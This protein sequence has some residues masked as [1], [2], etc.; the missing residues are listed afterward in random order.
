[1]RFRDGLLVLGIIVL[2]L[3]IF[4]VISFSDILTVFVFG[5]KALIAL[6]IIALIALVCFFIAIWYIFKSSAKKSTIIWV[7]YQESDL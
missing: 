4:G 7:N 5:I 1:M 3:L 6:V 2:V